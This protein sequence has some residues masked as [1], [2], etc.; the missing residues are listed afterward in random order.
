MMETPIKHLPQADQL[1]ERAAELTAHDE[2]AQLGESLADTLQ[3]LL[4]VSEMA[5]YEVLAFGA[6]TWL[7]AINRRPRIEGDALV[8]A[9]AS[10]PLIEK[11]VRSFQVA[12]AGDE[13]VYPIERGGQIIGVFWVRMQEA[14]ETP[15][16]RAFLRIFGNYVRLIHDSERDTLTGLY[17]R[18]RF[19]IRVQQ[20]LHNGMA[21]RSNDDG[22]HGSALAM[23]DID[24]F[25]RLNDNYGHLFGDEVLILI[26]RLMQQT[27]REND[28]LFRVGGEEFVLLLGGVDEQSALG[29][30]NRLRSVI[31]QYA[32]PQEVRVT[33]SI[34]VVSLDG[35]DDQG[36]AIDCADRALYYAKEHGR[37]QVCGYQHLIDTGAIE[38]KVR[39]SVLIELF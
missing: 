13:F 32:F 35:L 7:R 30:L 17:N 39:E 9:L 12:H 6:E 10:A 4:G 26:A 27:M 24:F 22:Q 3:E 18:R 23:L 21:R 5:L 29:P 11:S 38:P 1:L 37:N 34:G 20:A 16:L 28:Q 14:S 15:G 36:E 25:K 8:C 31:E 33:V 19:D 2:L